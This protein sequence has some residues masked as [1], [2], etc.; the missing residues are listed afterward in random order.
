MT[1]TS[2]SEQESQSDC[3]LIPGNLLGPDLVLCPFQQDPEI[4]SYVV[5]VG[6]ILIS[7]SQTAGWILWALVIRLGWA[8]WPDWRNAQVSCSVLRKEK[9][10]LL[11]Y[12]WG[13]VRFLTYTSLPR[14][15]ETGPGA[16]WRTRTTVLKSSWISGPKCTVLPLD[17]FVIWRQIT[18]TVLANWVVFLGTLNTFS[19]GLSPTSSLPHTTIRLST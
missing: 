15:L 11:G 17:F 7:Q 1:N 9:I 10:P 8:Y 6:S 13:Y 4:L 19:L 18:F 2:W 16:F 5:W 14:E 3:A 12:K